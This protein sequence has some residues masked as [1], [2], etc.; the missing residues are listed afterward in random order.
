MDILEK[1]STNAN[2]FMD[3]LSQSP[4][5]CLRLTGITAILSMILI[6]FIVSGLFEMHRSNSALK[7][8]R[9]QYCFWQKLLMIHAWQLCLHA[10]RFCRR[11]IIFHYIVP[12]LFAVE[13]LLVIC[14]SRFPSLMPVIAYY[15]LAFLLLV[16]FPVCIMHLCL[17]RHPFQRRKH[18]F[19]FRKYHNSKDHESLW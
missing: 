8:I 5:F 18:E 1:I 3:T 17:D 12:G 9:K 7:K 14:S 15:T 10:K 13:V 19:T 4:A 6:R 11:L 2:R 16:W